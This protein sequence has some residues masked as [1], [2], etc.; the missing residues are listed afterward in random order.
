MKLLTLRELPVG[1]FKG[2]RP[3]NGIWGLVSPP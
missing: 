2:K 3:E 1:H